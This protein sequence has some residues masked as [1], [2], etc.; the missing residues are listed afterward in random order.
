[1]MLLLLA[2]TELSSSGPQV[3]ILLSCQQGNKACVTS[4]VASSVVWYVR[5]AALT[6]LRTCNTTTSPALAVDVSTQRYSRLKRISTLKSVIIS[7]AS[8]I[9]KVRKIQRIIFF[10]ETTDTYLDKFVEG[11][12]TRHNYSRIFYNVMVFVFVRNCCF[13]T[14][15]SEWTDEA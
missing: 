14:D 1:M 12:V 5:A 13:W 11:K 6:D 7:F 10:E 4:I 9:L 15:C 3:F 2:G 8:F